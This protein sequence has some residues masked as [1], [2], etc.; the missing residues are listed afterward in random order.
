[1][2]MGTSIL[3]LLGRR[4]PRENLLRVAGDQPAEVTP[5]VPGAQYP[6][7]TE[8]EGGIYATQAAKDA[9]ATVPAQPA[10][11]PQP[12]AYQSPTELLGMYKELMEY[13]SKA[14]NLDRGIALLGSAF[15]HP[16]NRANIMQAFSP[17]SS[18]SDLSSMDPAAVWKSIQEIQAAETA[19]TQKAA[20]IAQLPMIAKKYGIDEA[21]AQ[22]LFQNEQLDDFIAE[23][24]KAT[25]TR[26]NEKP[27]TAVDPV[28]GQTIGFDPRKGRELFRIGDPKKPGIE[29]QKV[30]DDLYLFEK[31]TGKEIRRITN[32]DPEY[33]NITDTDGTTMI[34]DK[35]N[36]TKIIGRLGT[37]KVASS[38]DT[39]EY[40]RYV[41]Q[42]T[43]AGRPVKSLE[44]WILSTKKAGAN[45]QIVNIPAAEKKFAEKMGEEQGKRYVQY[46]QMADSARQMKSQ[47]DIAEKALDSGL[48][49][50][51]GADMMLA[52]RKAGQLF[53][54][55]VDEEKIAAA[56]TIK[57]ISNQLAMMKRNPE[58]GLGL[59]GS[60]SD[61]DLQFL[62]DADIQIGSSVE[63]NRTMIRIARKIAERNEQVAIKAAEYVEKNGQLDTGWEKELKRF[64]DENPLF[65]DLQIGNASP[66]ER[67]RKAFEKYGVPVDGN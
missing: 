27:T 31:D 65:D 34:V 60:V 10:A 33:L 3:N 48:D 58:S 46:Q 11:K 22:L 39:I 36:P 28:T 66:E 43:A 8:P 6:A 7:S 13:N 26:D 32:D 18:A 40:D 59:P 52:A 64:A 37:P 4:D 57:S 41:A 47:Y 14:Q 5:A 17:S 25:F 30:G 63:G 15:A 24:E 61:R 38:D 21:T 44:Q 9:A 67:K 29:F 16:E 19:R 42:E 2:S 50:G 49:T 56:E 45:Q 1:M 35:K 55:D 20:M 54:V 62:K 12:E 53:G 23:R 51:T